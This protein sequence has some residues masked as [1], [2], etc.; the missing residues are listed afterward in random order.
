M[1]LGA[2]LDLWER[3][4]FHSPSN[5]SGPLYPHHSRR[6]SGPLRIT[7]LE[8]DR[9]SLMNA[10][11]CREEEPS[12]LRKQLEYTQLKLSSAQVSTGALGRPSP[13]SH[14]GRWV[15]GVGGGRGAMKRKF[16][17]WPDCES[18]DIGATTCD[19]SHVADEKEPGSLFPR[20]EDG[21]HG[22]AIASL[23]LVAQAR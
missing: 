9:D 13:T 12:A 6:Q 21:G 16:G 3:D 15:V 22:P 5:S 7:E 10:M 17:A 2:G 4:K 8:R 14:S 18:C 19:A 23:C 1:G 20:V 11:A